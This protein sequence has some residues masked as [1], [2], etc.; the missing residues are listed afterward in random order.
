MKIVLTGPK[1]AG[2]SSIGR[3]AAERLNIPFVETDEIIESLYAD[4][5][6][7]R[8][9]CR[10]IW[11]TLGEEG[12]RAIERQA[13]EE[14]SG[15]DWCVLST[16]GATMLHPESR[17]LLQRDSIIVLLTSPADILWQRME[18]I[19]LPPFFAV[20]DGRER[21]EER[22]ASIDE[23]ILPVASF[24]I[25]SSSG[26][27]EEVADQVVC[28]IE[29]EM[30]LRANQPNTFGEIIR[31]TTFGESHGP[32]VGAVL[33]GVPPG[34][35]LSE[36]DVQK[37][38]DRRRPGQS[39]VVTPRNEAD[40]VHILSGVFEGKTTGAPIAMVIYNQDQDSSKYEKLRD[41]FRPGH[42]D[43][44][45]WHKYGIRDHRGG[46]RSS[47]RETAARVAGGAIAKKILQER[48]INITA[49]ALEIAGI[50]AQTI[51]HSQIEKNSVRSPDPEA[52]ARME[53]AIL[54]ARAE[55]D[56]VGGIVQ[57]E[58]TGV[59]VGLGDPVFW[60][61]DAR[62][63]MALLS[64]GAV[65]GI[66][67]GEG[68]GAARMRGSENNDQMQDGRF[69]TNHAGGLLG[70]MST[71][72]PIIA[73]LAVKPTASIARPQK[74][75]DTS[76]ENREITVEGRHDPCIVP[77]VVP[78]VESMAALVILDALCAQERIRAASGGFAG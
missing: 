58:I 76:G 38:L 55:K 52:A 37:E 39:N 68:F 17:R 33:D 8:L 78:V 32:A 77:R 21:F 13:V 14:A 20:P 57:L 71:G 46:G 11:K 62:L 16:G 7:E 48:G 50:R 69:L 35:E 36:E 23:A 66:E 18:T 43:F 42:A 30:A 22:L 61:L 10:E 65:K 5:H 40:R 49:Y 73:R 9:T 47:G 24:V 26:T 31:V 54:A 60:K 74:T 67:F 70:G 6:G 44:T 19:G 2:K 45:F 29:E 3:I 53:E 56:S 4:A 27:P 15:M 51:D 64:L 63:G 75:I 1:C 28:G 72:E 41:V 34:I 12:F 25:D 59:P